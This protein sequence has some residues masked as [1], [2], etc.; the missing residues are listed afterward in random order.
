MTILDAVREG[1]AS[2]THRLSRRKGN[3]R[4]RSVSDQSD[5][6]FAGATL[7]QSRPRTAPN[8]KPGLVARAWN[9]NAGAITPPA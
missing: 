3:V 8:K 5:A 2:H 6:E 4:G 9:G 7:V 1:T